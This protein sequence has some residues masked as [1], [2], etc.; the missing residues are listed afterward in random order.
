MVSRADIF[1]LGKMAN[2]SVLVNKFFSEHTKKLHRNIKS[3]HEI[4][5]TL[6]TASFVIFVNNFSTCC[7]FLKIIITRNAELYNKLKYFR[8]E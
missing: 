3:L 4:K 8:M 6:T 7:I 1:V 5:L 2:N